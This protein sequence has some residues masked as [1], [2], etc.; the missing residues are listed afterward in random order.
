[1]GVLSS[2][3]LILVISCYSVLQNYYIFYGTGGEP[4]VSL[5]FTTLIGSMLSVGLA[6]GVTIALGGLLF[7]QVC[8]HSPH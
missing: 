3:S 1:M 6:V 2:L 8:C 4:L 7:I 5:G